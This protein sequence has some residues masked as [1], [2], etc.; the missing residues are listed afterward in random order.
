[1]ITPSCGRSTPRSKRAVGCHVLDGGDGGGG[2]AVAAR[3]PAH[4]V[5]EHG[6]D[7]ARVAGEPAGGGEAEEGGAVGEVGPAGARLD[8]GAVRERIDLDAGQRAGPQQQGVAE[9][10]E[11]R[12][13]MTAALGNDA[14]PAPARL[15]HGL[16]DPRLVHGERHAGGPLVDGEVERPSG[17]VPA[18]VPGLEDREVRGD[19][20][21][22]RA[23]DHGREH[24]CP[25]TPG[26]RG[27]PQTMT[28]IFAAGSPRGAASRT[29]RTGT[30]R[31]VRFSNR[32]STPASATPPAREWIRTQA[33]DGVD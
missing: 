16:D 12:G 17:R 20:G 5:A 1:V 27:H 15:A 6:A 19:R 13:A 11:P 3:Q 31:I 9:R 26:H 14:E 28:P 18:R 32:A 33:P 10:A 7:D 4:P 25:C 8:A 30:H 2:E 24:R 23:G 21:A 29:P 22:I